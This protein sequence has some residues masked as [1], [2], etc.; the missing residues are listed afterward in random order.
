MLYYD[1]YC[2]ATR[3]L[4]IKNL[5]HV[6]NCDLVQNIDESIHRIERT[7]RIGNRG[8]AT[9]FNSSNEDIATN[10]IKV[11]LESS[12]EILEFLSP[13]TRLAK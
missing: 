12:P 3:G 10:L 9:S 1:C 5:M 2:Y 6:I 4:G 7:D 13:I 8:L 11:L